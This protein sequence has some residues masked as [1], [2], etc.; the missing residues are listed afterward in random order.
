MQKIKLSRRDFLKL[1]STTAAGAFLA[2][3]A[4]KLNPTPAATGIPATDVPVAKFTGELQFWDWNFEPRQTY[5]AELFPAWQEAN[6]GI[7]INYTTQEWGDAQTRLLTAASAGNPPPMANIHSA[8]RPDLQRSG[9]LVPYPEDLLPFDKLL[10]TPFL[11]DPGTGR[12]YSTT[13]LYYCDQLYLNT[14]LLE[15]EGIAVE[16]VPTKWEEY[17]LMC[18]Q[19]TKRDSS[20]VMTQAG[21]TLNHYYSREWLWQT[22]LYQMGGWQWTEDGQRANWNCPEGVEALQMI[23]DVYHKY[24]IDDP[25]FLGLFDAFGTNTAASFI[26]QGYIGAGLDSWYPDVVG[27]W[28]TLKTPTFTGGLPDHAWGVVSPEEGLGVFEGF[29]QE[30]VDACFDFI[31]FAIASDENAIKW[32]VMGGG[33]CDRSDLLSHPDLLA[34]D[35]NN[36]IA[37]QADTL[38]YR[39][40]YGERPLEAE[41]YWRDMFDAVILLDADPQEALDTAT[42]GVNSELDAAAKTRII[43]ERAYQQPG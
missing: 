15:A 33:P 23:K 42:E 39:V 16:D 3:C 9:N 8:W 21:M 26:S 43:T 13:F 27:K 19:L 22:L 4:P 5:F 34:G 41:K 14:A 25:N 1:T 2:S 29:P 11:R 28:T 38:P 36:V 10:S 12:I 32:A 18:Q 37:T 7:T 20:D 6:P 35:H 40:N 31:K 30:E 24:K 17:F